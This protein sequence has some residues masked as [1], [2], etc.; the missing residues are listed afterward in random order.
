M[1]R[2]TACTMMIWIEKF[3]Q[4]SS[5][6]HL[7]STMVGEVVKIQCIWPSERLP[8]SFLLQMQIVFFIRMK[9]VR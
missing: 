6:M 2:K 9:T 5:S 7:R 4:D 8:T 1:C 3:C